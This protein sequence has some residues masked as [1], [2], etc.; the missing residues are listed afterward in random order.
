MNFIGKRLG[1]FKHASSFT[2]KT[3]EIFEDIDNMVSTSLFLQ[4]KQTGN[5][6]YSDFSN[7]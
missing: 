1:S 6:I 3:V 4:S 2:D 5:E 7:F